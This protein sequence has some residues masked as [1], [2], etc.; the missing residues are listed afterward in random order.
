[1]AKQPETFSKELQ[2][3]LRGRKPKTLS[4]LT[5]LFAERS[6]AI[7]FLLLMALPALPLPTGGVT[8]VTELITMLLCLELIIGRRTVWLPKRWHNVDVGKHLK[9]KAGQKL[10]GIIQWFERF[11][12]QRGEA[13][14]RQRNVLSVLG[15]VILIL[16]FAA[17][18]A[19]PFSGLD[20]LP[21]LGVVVMSL[22]IIL[23]DA[24]IVGIGF[25]LGLMGVSLELV[26]GASIYHEI[27]HLHWF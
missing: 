13:A 18:I 21:S 20:T 22:G 19:P 9:G 8:H 2:R 14:L 11:S 4:S 10:I 16:T 1:M 26:L 24:L 27:R 15:L 5:E 23:E 17:F 12:Q 7:I 6:F 3:W 25:I